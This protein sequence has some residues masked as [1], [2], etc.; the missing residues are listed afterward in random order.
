MA[1]AA[2]IAGS[3]N[4]APQNSRSAAT[5]EISLVVDYADAPLLHMEGRGASTHEILLSLS[6]QLQFNY[7]RSDQITDNRPV[8]SAISGSVE[9]I[10]DWLLFGESY[11]MAYSRTP[12]GAKLNNVQ[13][14]G[15]GERKRPAAATNVAGAVV[16]TLEKSKI[17]DYLASHP[18]TNEDLH[19]WLEQRAAD[20]SRD[21]GSV[22]I[23]LYDAPASVAELLQRMAEPTTT[24]F[25]GNTN[26]ESGGWHSSQTSCWRQRCRTERRRRSLGANHS[27]GTEKRESARRGAAKDLFRRFLRS[28]FE[29]EYDPG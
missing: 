4:E 6:E 1:S 2:S 22:R 3:D 15:H 18:E 9:E 21:G 8:T 28:A 25:A 5:T 14:L 16:I 7:S 24:D 27:H 10:V 13:W 29:L 12:E 17:T 19:R 23:S 20:Q 26:G 11:V